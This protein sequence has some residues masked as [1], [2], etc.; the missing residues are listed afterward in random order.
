MTQEVYSPKHCREAV[1]VAANN[2]EQFL[3]WVRFYCKT[4]TVEQARAGMKAYGIAVDSPRQFT[5]NR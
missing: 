3:D 5:R 2:P 4:V 1:Q